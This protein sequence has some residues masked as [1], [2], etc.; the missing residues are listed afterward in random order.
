MEAKE[1][2]RPRH[3]IAIDPDVDRS[4]VAF[5]YLPSR[6]LHCEARTFPELIDDLH[7]TKQAT[8]ALGESLTVVVE[9][10][11]LNRS[12][13]HVQAGDSRRKA[14]AIGRAAGRNHEVGRKI[15]EMARHMG[16]EVVEQ[17]PLQKC[18]R[19]TG[20][21]I[22][23]EELAAF[24]GYTARTSQDMRDAALLAWVYAG[25]A[26]MLVSLSSDSGMRDAMAPAAAIFISSLISFA[27]TSS[28]PRKM[29]G[30]ASRLL[31]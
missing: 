2:K 10:G 18:W 22:T 24:T 5:L 16:L 31:T 11:W 29:P 25:L 7:A 6:E 1:E 26:M 30:K 14:A 4:G 23:H 15:V 8:D 27:R 20:R 9:A 12:N 28:A 21:K 17:R 13:W 3:I 19:G